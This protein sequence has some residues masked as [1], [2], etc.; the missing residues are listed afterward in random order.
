MS[1]SVECAVIGAGVVGLAVARELALA[2]LETVVLERAVHVGTGASSRNSEVIHAGIYYP[3][4][5]LKAETCVAGKKL[6]YTYCESRGIAHRRCGKLIV[7]TATAQEAALNAIITRA[8]RSGV[9]D[10]ERLTE[11]QVQAVE[12]AVRCVAGV[13]SPSTGIIDSHSLM[14]SLQGDFEAA[15]GMIG[16]RSPVV[17]GRCSERRLCLEVGEGAATE[18]HARYVV[19]SAGLHAPAVAAGLQGFPKARVPATYF[20]KGSYFTLSGRAPF[21]HLVYPVPEPGG[22]GVH[23]TLDLAGQGRFGPDVEWIDAIDYDVDPARAERFYSEIRRYWPGLADGA[24]VPAYAGIRAKLHGPEEQPADFLLQG[25][26]VHGVP[27]LVNLFGIE[28]PGLT[29]SLAVARKVRQL[30]LDD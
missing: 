23:L 30:L 6:L 26:N 5:S 9:D 22:L 25:E 12:P 17:G 11:A 4:A 3:P 18:L 7:A 10:L 13:L 29:A 14:L 21:S 20:A 15:G 19:N 24:L 28:S 27:R 16:F 2:G 1:D 8:A